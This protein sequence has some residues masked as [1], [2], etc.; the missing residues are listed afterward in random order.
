M[1]RRA[2]TRFRRRSPTEIVRSAASARPDGHEHVRATRE[3]RLAQRGGDSQWEQAG[4]AAFQEYTQHIKRVASVHIRKKASW[5]GNVMLCRESYLKNDYSYFPSDVVPV[6]ATASASLRRI[7]GEDV[8]DD[9]ASPSTYNGPPPPTLHT[10][11]V[12][13]LPP[14]GT[15]TYARREWLGQPCRTPDHGLP[16]P[17]RRQWGLWDPERH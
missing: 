3:Q 12:P 2:C 6:L 13:Y 8:Q 15:P 10:R 7:L 1:Y 16:P 14:T 4:T 17:L 9:K 11:T 5:A